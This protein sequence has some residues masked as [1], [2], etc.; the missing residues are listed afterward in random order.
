MEW[1][2]YVDGASNIKGSGAGAVLISPNGLIL[3]QAVRLGFLA[4]NNKT[5][6]EALLIG[7]KSAKRLRA[8]RLQVFYD[9][10][11]VTHQ[12]SGEYQARDERMSAYLLAV[13]SLLSKFEFTQIRREH[14]SHADI[15]AK[16]ATALETNLH[17]IVSVKILDFPSFRSRGPD[18][19]STTGSGSNWMDPLVA[20]LQ[21]NHLP[22][23]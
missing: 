16:L 23:D 10:Q 15:L 21:D 4:S 14:N 2:L 3:E 17:K 9:S 19:I 5:K 18:T 20:Y 12:I 1:K 7:L 6:Y 13:Q 11:L 22:K 8:D